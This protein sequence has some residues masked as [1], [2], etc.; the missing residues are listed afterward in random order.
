MAELTLTCPPSFIIEGQDVGLQWEHYLETFEM[1]FVA[2][3][4]ADPARKQTLLL[5]CGGDSL[6]RVY[7]T[8]DVKLYDAQGVLLQESGVNIDPYKKTVKAL[9]DYFTPKT[10]ITYQRSKFR[11]AKQ[12]DAEPALKFIT[13]LRELGNLCRFDVYNTD[14]AIVDQFIEKCSSSNLRRML[15]KEETLDVATIITKAQAEESA[16]SHADCMEKRSNMLPNER[17]DFEDE[18]VMYNSNKRN[19]QR[20]QFKGKQRSTPS[21]RTFDTGTSQYSDGNSPGQRVF[22]FGCGSSTHVHNSNNCPARGKTCNYCQR[23]GHFKS[24]CQKLKSKAK[25][26]SGAPSTSRNYN[27]QQSRSVH[28]MDDQV[29]TEEDCMYNRYN[30]D[31]SDKDDFLFTVNSHPGHKRINVEMDFVTVNCIIDSGSTCN[32]I[33][34][35]TYNQFQGNVKVFPTN[36]KV[37]VYGAKEPLKLMGVFY[38]TIMF[39]NQRIIAPVLVSSIYD[40]GCILSGMTC[41]D[42][43][44]LDVKT[45]K[46]FVNQNHQEDES[47]HNMLQQFEG[48]S[49]GIGKLKNCNLSLDIDHSVAPVVQRDRRIPF[50]LR[51][52]VQK[53]VSYLLDQDI[54]EHTPAPTTWCSPIVVVN[55]KEGRIR[56]CLDLRQANQA[57]MRT[58]YPIP[59]VNELLEKVSGSV[60]FSKIDLRAGYYQI[61][62]DETSRNIT[63]FSTPTGLYR[64]KR[65]VFGLKSASEQ[66]QNIIGNLFREEPNICNISD[67]ILVYGKNKQ[68]HSAALHRCLT[69]L[70]ENGLTI[71]REKCVFEKE[72]IQFFGYVISK[73]GI[74]PTKEK[75]DD[76]RN[77]P[78]PENVKELRSFL[79]LI[80][81]LGKFIPDLATECEPLRVLTRNSVPW[82]W[83][84]EEQRCFEKLKAL[85]TTTK[86]MAHFD[87]DLD[88]RVITDASPVGLGGIMMQRHGNDCWKVVEY[89]S[90]SLTPV[91][92]RYSQTEREALGVVWALEKLDLYLCGKHFTVQTDHKPLIGVFKPAA[93]TS[94]RLLRWAL[95]LQPY[96]FD[97]EY[98]PGETNPADGLSRFPGKMK[99]TD[100][101]EKFDVEKQLNFMIAHTLP[102]SL[103]L[104]DFLEAAKHDP[105]VKA[106]VEA[107]NSDKWYKS[108]YTKSYTD[109]KNEF[110]MKGG[111]LLRGDRLFVPKLLRQRVFDIIHETHLGI[112]KSLQ[113]LRTKVWWPKMDE[114]VRSRI[115]ACV[116]CLSVQPRSKHEPY[117]MTVL[118]NVWENIHVDICGPLPDGL[119][120]LGIVDEGSRWPHIYVIRS[121]KT[122]TVVKKLTDLFTTMGKVKTIISDNGPQF[123]SNEFKQFCNEWGV[124][125]RRVIPYHPQ[126][127]GEIERLFR[128]VMKIIKIAHAQNK[129]WELP[130][131]KFLMAYRN[132]PHSMTGVSPASLIFGHQ[133]ADKLPK[134]TDDT[135]SKNKLFQYACKQDALNKSKAKE[136]AD[137][138]TKQ[139]VLKSGDVVLVAQKRINKF[140]TRF[141]MEKFVIVSSGMGGFTIKSLTD[142]REYIRHSTD[143]KKVE[144]ATAQYSNVKRQGEATEKP[145]INKV[146]KQ[147]SPEIVQSKIR[148]GWRPEST[149]FRETTAMPAESVPR[150]TCNTSD[151]INMT[152]VR[153]S[154]RT[155][156]GKPPSRIVV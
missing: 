5:Y 145:L 23:P 86:V 75:V 2:A 149:A 84:L 37:F 26:G 105:E 147:M 126:S 59:T 7:K 139:S 24:V 72:S 35:K 142:G 101:E 20:Q 47:I 33:D 51:A 65:L 54:I 93:K 6:R 106:I 138:G 34:L 12:E 48:I 74:R 89:I 45:S 28:Y 133:L 100:L 36:K 14:A 123:I 82:Q 121:T 136:Y 144:G 140:S 153:W 70:K 60:L 16:N 50:H 71:N 17:F 27:S 141:S 102:K 156:K 53:E 78:S 150:D 29:E 76:V 125:H 108:R 109:L 68:E 64:F 81:Y 110:S 96:S 87:K 148:F 61:P 46:E 80:N 40:A 115:R 112:T 135:R 19:N 107:L 22:C 32:M 62:L 67:D 111:V 97:L 130:L 8:L 49:D 90:R 127:N 21:T 57:I 124:L 94:A 99:I 98:I 15:L 73:D 4:V 39:G 114:F 152:P 66:Y 134:F 91:E 43:G 10:N 30:N 13:R 154:T 9:T 41:T 143:L 79:G 128:T 44:V 85:V 55:R 117:R 3:N 18:G 38:P 88:T 83:G 69:I 120:I 122:E 104:S 77:F 63:T 119:S 146:H 155:N 132:M 113:L 31:E 95:R 25:N 118:P 103:V 151:G 129:N 56:L 58:H 137:K 52:A 42:L 131:Q 92:R 116:H 1:Y 11:E